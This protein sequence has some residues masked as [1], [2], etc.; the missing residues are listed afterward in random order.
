MN[1]R[2][3]SRETKLARTV[4]DQDIR[5]RRWGGVRSSRSWPLSDKGEPGLKK[6]FFQP[7]GPQFGLKIRGPGT[8]GTLPWICSCHCKEIPRGKNFRTLILGKKAKSYQCHFIPMQWNLFGR[9]CRLYYF[10]LER[11]TW[12]IKLYLCLVSSLCCS[13]DL[14]PK[15]TASEMRLNTCYHQRLDR[16]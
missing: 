16:E 2:Q 9:P 12:T 1:F 6:P 8:P 15:T 13:L 10:R 11:Q 7:L 3:V 5:I 14:R 4:A